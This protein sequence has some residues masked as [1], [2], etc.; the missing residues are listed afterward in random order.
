MLRPR[1]EPGAGHLLRSLGVAPA[2]VR[3]GEGREGGR[4]RVS[5]D[6]AL[7]AFDLSDGELRFGHRTST[8]AT[9]GTLPATSPESLVG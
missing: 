6:D 3:L 1:G 4:A 2:A 5:P 7:E 9:G 8:D